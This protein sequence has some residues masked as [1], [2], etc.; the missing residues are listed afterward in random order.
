MEFNYIAE[1]FDTIAALSG[2]IG[3]WLNANKKRSCFIM[4]SLC[5]GYWCIRNFYLGL[6]SQTFF[7]L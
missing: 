7:V 2:W 1:L 5:T 4:F 3:R 6:Y